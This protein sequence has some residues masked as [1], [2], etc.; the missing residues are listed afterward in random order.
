MDEFLFQSPFR[1]PVSQGHRPKGKIIPLGY[2]LQ[3]RRSLSS[4]RKLISRAGERRVMYV[5]GERTEL[6]DDGNHF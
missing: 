3:L 2:A 5:R 1:F 6:M 4:L